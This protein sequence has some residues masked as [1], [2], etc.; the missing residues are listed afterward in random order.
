MGKVISGINNKNIKLNILL[1]FINFKQTRSNF[2]KI[3]KKT[4]VIISIFAGQCLTQE[5]KMT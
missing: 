5:K 4:K 3:N 1:Q 2:K